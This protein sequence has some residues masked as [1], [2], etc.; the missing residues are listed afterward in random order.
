MNS[1]GVSVLDGS[2]YSLLE[3]INVSGRTVGYTLVGRKSV[4]I[5]T[6]AAGRSQDRLDT[7]VDPPGVRLEDARAIDDHGG[8]RAQR[9]GRAQLSAGPALISR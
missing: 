6:D 7:L 8:H 4:A 1:L 9:R 2:D 5:I 3:G